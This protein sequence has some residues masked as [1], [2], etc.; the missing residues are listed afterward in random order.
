MNSAVKYPQLALPVNPLINEPDPSRLM[1]GLRDTGYD[2]YTAAADIIDNSIAA[3]AQNIQ[4]NIELTHDGRKFVYFGDDGH[5]MDEKALYNAMRYGA[6]IRADLASLG[7]FGLGLKT[8]SS[9]VC[10]N[11]SLISRTGLNEPLNKLTWDLEHVM[12][13]N[14]WEMKADPL[15]T[16]KRSCLRSFAAIRGLLW[17]GQDAIVC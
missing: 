7:K 3:E 4:I 1:Y 9:A 10:L 5:G 11:Y 14:T 2:F 12:E 6:K 16:M 8:A 17:C 15:R 13:T